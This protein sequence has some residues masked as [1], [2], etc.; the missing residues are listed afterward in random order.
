MSNVQPL[1]AY[2]RNTVIEIWSKVRDRR[3]EFSR[4]DVRR[5]VKQFSG[6][7]IHRYLL[8]FEQMGL[9][10]RVGDERPFTWRVIR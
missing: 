2:R 1:D 7:T 9:I 4:H 3:L 6:R 8:L 5:D 10:M